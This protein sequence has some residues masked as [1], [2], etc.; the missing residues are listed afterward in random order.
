MKIKFACALIGL[1]FLIF[2]GFSAAVETQRDT[3]ATEKVVETQAKDIVSGEDQSRARSFFANQSF[4]L[5]FMYYYFDYKE[6]LPAPFK[7]TESGWLPGVYIGWYYNKKNAVYSKVFFEFSY[8]DTEFDGTTQAGTPIKFK[9]DNHQFLFRGEWDIGYNFGLTKDISIKPYTGYG[10]RL[11]DRGYAK[12]TAAYTSYKERYYWHY[13]PVG[14][15]ADF[16]VGD[17]LSIEPNAGA[18]IMFYGKMTAY[19]SEVDPGYNDPEFKLGNKVGWYAEIPLKYR[20]SQSWSIV[21]K[22]WYEYSA[23]GESDVSALTYYG[24]LSGYY[25]EPTSKTN[26]YG[27][28]VGVI[29]S[30]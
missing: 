7:S 30:F 18:R 29:F 25:Y 13:I 23:I 14:I 28:N 27:V 5:S 12:R 20:L 9:E 24:A 16:N 21:V 11:W 6:D 2:P 1:L 3:V 26:Q 10:F 15:M 17:K 8:G 19:F 22:P 4:E